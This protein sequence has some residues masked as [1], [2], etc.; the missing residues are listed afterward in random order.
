MIYI[1]DYLTD[2]GQPIVPSNGYVVLREPGNT[3]LKAIAFQIC[4]S[5]GFEYENQTLVC[6]DS[7]WDPSPLTSCT[8]FG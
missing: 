6:T 1:V 5:E 2:C 4:D 3:T 7:G 8:G